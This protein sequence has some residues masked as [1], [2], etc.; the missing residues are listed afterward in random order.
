M[1]ST[2]LTSYA[3]MSCASLSAA[4]WAAAL[5]SSRERSVAV[6]GKAFGRWYLEGLVPPR[7]FPG[8]GAQWAGMGAQLLQTSPVFAARLNE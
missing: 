7:V 5:M 3:M 1:E 8:Q 6:T 4:A 2:S